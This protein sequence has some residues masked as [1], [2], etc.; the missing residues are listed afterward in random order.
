MPGVNTISI[1]H[2]FPGRIGSFV[3]SGTV[4]VHDPL[5]LVNING[6]APVFVTSNVVTYF[7]PRAIGPKLCSNL[8][9]LMLV[10]G[11]SVDTPNLSFKA[12]SCFKFAISFLASDSSTSI[13]S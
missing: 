7:S 1:V 10:I 12:N 13:F 2:F 3:Y 9:N 5:T 11:N 8:S 6:S 4:H